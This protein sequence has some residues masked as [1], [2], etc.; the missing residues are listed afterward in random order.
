LREL[1][2]D[3]EVLLSE[4]GVVHDDVEAKTRVRGRIESRENA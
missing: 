4:L 3:S 1:V 2:V